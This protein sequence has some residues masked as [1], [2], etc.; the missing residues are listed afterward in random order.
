MNET[1]KLVLNEPTKILRRIQ[2]LSRKLENIHS[3]EKRVRERILI[4]LFVSTVSMKIKSVS[5]VKVLRG[6][7]SN[8]SACFSYSKNFSMLNIFIF[9]HVWNLSTWCRSRH[10]VSKINWKKNILKTQ[11]FLSTSLQVWYFTP[12]LVVSFHK[13][14]ILAKGKRIVFAFLHALD[15]RMTLSHM[16]LL[17]KTT[18]RLSSRLSSDGISNSEFTLPLVANHHRKWNWFRK[19]SNRVRFLAFDIDQT[20]LDE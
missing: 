6:S 4:F 13:N 3:T 1:L 8:P 5:R 2:K 19:C 7:S 12:S 14:N 16:E 18:T 20:S 15:V 17:C 11:S 10:V 9:K